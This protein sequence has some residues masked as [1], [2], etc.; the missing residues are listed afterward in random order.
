MGWFGKS[1]N[2]NDLR[3][4]S[5]VEEDDEDDEDEEDDEDPKKEC[6]FQYNWDFEYEAWNCD[7]TNENVYCENVYCDK[8][9]CPFWKNKTND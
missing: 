1:E 9:K 6:T 2:E 7:L 5:K 3:K 8:T 4:T